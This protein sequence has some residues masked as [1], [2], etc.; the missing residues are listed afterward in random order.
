M[1]KTTTPKKRKPTRKHDHDGEWVGVSDEF[2]QQVI[3]EAKY[4]YNEA[5]ELEETEEH[6]ALMLEGVEAGVFSKKAVLLRIMA[7][8]AFKVVYRTTLESR[9]PQLAP[10]KKRK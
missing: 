3:D 1:R 5:A 9:L 6:F 10:K 2:L 7:E 8:V 4:L